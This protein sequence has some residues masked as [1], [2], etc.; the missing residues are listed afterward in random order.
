[1]D[2]DAVQGEAAQVSATR[3]RPKSWAGPRQLLTAITLVDLAFAI[4]GGDSLLGKVCLAILLP[5]APFWIV[6]AIQA[7]I[8]L[9]MKWAGVLRV[10]DPA[11]AASG[12]SGAYNS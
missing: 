8:Y 7:P 11:E 1:M 3:P 6:M 5:L 12:E 2:D 4:W 9:A 10:G